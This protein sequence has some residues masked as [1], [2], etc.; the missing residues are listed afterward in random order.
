MSLLNLRFQLN[1]RMVLYAVHK[2]SL[3]STS[4]LTDSL[5]GT[6]K[7]VGTWLQR[8]LEYLHLW[9]KRKFWIHTFGIITMHITMYI[10]TVWLESFGGI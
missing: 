7:E 10:N 1:T 8:L 6:D 3:S 4:C 2:S 9:W 5:S